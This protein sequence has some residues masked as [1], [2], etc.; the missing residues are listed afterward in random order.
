[1][2]SPQVLLSS[3][4]VWWAR[5]LGSVVDVCLG[6]T[7]VIV[8]GLMATTFEQAELYKQALLLALVGAALLAWS[9]K[10]VLERRAEV[11]LGWPQLFLGLFGV[12]TLISAGLSVHRY[13][14]FVGQFGQ[15]AWAVS[16]VCAF[17]AL[18]WLIA[19]RTRTAAQVYNVVFFFLVGCFGTGAVGLGLL[20]R[21][22]PLN[23]TG[24]GYALAVFM[25]SALVV[26]AGLVFHGCRSAQCL[27]R[28]PRIAGTL[29]RVLVW[30]VMILSLVILL[31]VNFWVAWMISLVGMIVLLLAGWISVHE[32]RNVHP[33]MV[34]PSLVFVLALGYLMF[35]PTWHMSLPGEVALSQR[36]SWDITQQTL[37]ARPLFGMGPGTWAYAHALYRPQTVNLSPFWSTYFDRGISSLLT[38][39]ATTGI[40]GILAFLMFVVSLFGATVQEVLSARR[41]AQQEDG[42]YAALLPFGGWVTLLASMPFYNFNVS[43]QL[44]FW[45]LTGC[46]LGFGA[47]RRVALD[48][49]RGLFAILFPVKAVL[50]GLVVL[51]VWVLGGQTLWAEARLGHTVEAYQAGRISADQAI[52][53]LQAI[54]AV[55]PWDD[56]SARMLSQAYL[57]RVLQRAKDKPPAEQAQMVGDDVSKMVDA[58]L[59]AIRLNPA[60]VENWSH[61]GLVYS[62]VASFTRGADA[63]ALKNYQEAIHRDPQNP[64]YPTAIGKLML[65]HADQARTLLDAKDPAIARKAKQDEAEALG[66]AVTWLR[67]GVALKADY[68]PAM[69]Y[70]AV[71]L[72]REGKTAE[73]ISFLERVATQDQSV[74]RIFELGM[75]YDRVGNRAKAIEAFERVVA[76]DATQMRAHFQLASLYEAAG[77][78]REAVAQLHLVAASMPANTAVQKRLQVLEV[79]ARGAK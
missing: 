4:R 33:R 48:G 56:V 9:I 78:L 32:G 43:H 72:D 53:S 22:A 12:T 52:E 34:V 76:V 18:A 45:T 47:R 30:V 67:N 73:A 42:W 24:S 57:V 6:L 79:K 19:Q 68:V 29:A 54:R 36:A 3:R 70:L 23:A 58:A 77:R 25:A 35:S 74:D 59:E 60:N 69:Y 50:V 17:I 5:F 44:L 31:T 41:G 39:L 7:I 65:S 14:S 26:T 2:S 55:H 16:T 37:V 75:L 40:I 38:L 46:L 51:S 28:S 20:I 15:R 64:L 10:I 11:A 66:Q 71:A 8:P 62:N 63:F 1:M 27:F 49:T 61:A 13:L 21:H